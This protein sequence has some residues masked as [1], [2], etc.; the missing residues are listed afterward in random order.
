MITILMR[1]LLNQAVSTQQ[2]NLPTHPGRAPTPFSVRSGGLAEQQP[3]QIPV[4][5]SAH[6]PSTATDRLEPGA[7]RAPEGISPRTRFPFNCSPSQ[8][9]QPGRRLDPRQRPQVALVALLRDAERGL[10]EISSAVECFLCNL[11]NLWIQCA[12]V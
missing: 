12:G 7:V 8:F 9:L 4:A 2:P 5:E 3:L 1:H 11:R 6:R 10:T